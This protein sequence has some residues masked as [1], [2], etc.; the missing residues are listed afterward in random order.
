M[1]ED[2]AT[3]AVRDVQP[4]QLSD[5]TPAGRWPCWS[6][7]RGYEVHQGWVVTFFRADL[8][9]LDRKVVCP[10]CARRIKENQRR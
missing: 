4:L 8:G 1:S 10:D 3:L 2:L 7:N 9:W 5:A 6:C